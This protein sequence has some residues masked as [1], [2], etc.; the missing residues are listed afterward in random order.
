MT[1]LQE[2]RDEYIANLNLLRSNDESG[3]SLGSNGRKPAEEIVDKM[4]ETVY[5]SSSLGGNLQWLKYNKAMK[6][7]AKKFG[8]T[9][10]PAFRDFIVEIVA[11]S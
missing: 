8:I 10:E 9:K 11:H 3:Y 6:L 7:A 2:F 1:K 4:I 5:K